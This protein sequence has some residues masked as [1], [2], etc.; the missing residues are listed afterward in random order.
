MRIAIGIAENP[1]H[2]HDAS[3]EFEDEPEDDDDAADESASDS[4]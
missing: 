2:E 3:D 1:E 4:V